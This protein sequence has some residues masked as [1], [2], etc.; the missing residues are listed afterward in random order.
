MKHSIALFLL[1]IFISSCKKEDTIW[2]TDWS[3]PLIN[4]TL[5]L[6]HLVNDT[7][8]AESGGYYVLDLTR[9]LFDLKVSDFVSIPDTTIEQTFAFGGSITLAPGFSF[10]NSPTTHDLDMEDLELKL[11]ILKA[12]YIDLRVE[13]PLGTS[14]IFNISLPGV[15]KDGVTFN[16]QY[17]APPGTQANPGIKLASIDLK[18]YTI[19]LTGPSGA[20]SNLLR[21][22]V[23]VSTD[24]NGIPIEITPSDITRVKAT[25]RDVQLDYARGYFG[26]RIV[27]DTSNVFLE[28]MNIVESGM[29]DLPN[30][31][32]TFEIE[33]GIKVSAQGTISTANNTNNQGNT[34]HLTGGQMGTSF[35]IDPA[36]GNWNSLN[37]SNKSI[38]FNS[39]N[40]NIENYIENLG[41]SHNLGYSLQLN[42]WGNVSGSYDELFPTSRLTI[43]MKALM[44]LNIGL[45]DL[46]LRDTFDITLNQNPD[47]TH[48]KSGELIL[49]ASNGFP[50]SGSVKIMLLDAN[51]QVL[52]TVLGSSELRSSVYGTFK[53]EHNINVCDS[54][55]HFVLPEEAVAVVNNVKKIIV[56]SKFNSPN[57]V[58]N[59]NEQVSIPVGAFLGVKVKTK[60]VTEN[61]F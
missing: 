56:E 10:V 21:S 55:I 16:Q 8:L 45:Y 30:T 58:S 6:A 48:V 2:E 54:E 5:S 18:G 61:R 24:P 35:N 31:S 57:S 37:P 38:A 28:V 29:I 15:T 7:T 33:N 44:P 60:F 22:S 9:T 13:N 32:I 42:P 49:K 19:D 59:L 51:G 36:T 27:S 1:L 46:T 3:A 41:A 52:H 23:N 50:I 14:T 47:K 34:V 11:I 39:G 25:F 43:K 12:G 26:N 53:P 40:S 4:D 20:S 17:I